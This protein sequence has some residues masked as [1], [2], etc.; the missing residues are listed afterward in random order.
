LDTTIYD[1]ARRAR[2]SI[3]TV[4]RVLNHSPRVAAETRLRVLS[5]AE[6][7]NYRP[8]ASARSL[9]QKK[10]QIVAAVIPVVTNYF[11][12]E[13]LRG[14]QDALEESEFDLIIY[15]A[16]APEAIGGQLE[17]ALQKG[18]S[19]GLVLVST[20]PSDEQ[21]QL[22]LG[23]RQPVVLV[24]A[25]H[26]AFDSIAV[27]NVKGAILAT[28]HLIASGRRR[29]AH[30]TISPEAPPAA[31][32]RKGYEQALREAGMEVDARLIVASDKRPYGF[33]EEAGYEAM[34]K[35]LG[36]RAVPDGVFAASDMQAL[37]AIQAIREAGLRVPE[38]IAV[39][40]FDN[41]K[42]A[43]YVGLT[44]LG[45]PMY[46]MGRLSAQKLITR[47]KEGD[48]PT[49]HTIFAPRLVCRQSCGAEAA[50]GTPVETISYVH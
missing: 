38:D 9:A 2:V 44:T 14:M 27:D 45:Q 23:S 3:A 25:V 10:T 12:M 43:A 36:S 22:L 20:R 18:R 46:E 19:D 28:R 39:V 31:Q 8:H 13:I 6:D 16:S 30:L 42:I 48:T 21:V 11:Y 26:S 35:L 34:R 15:A 32:R 47:L 50:A 4:S 49:S 17:R 1:I 7:L 24:D 33:V 29:I 37:G 41:V 40:G 5:A